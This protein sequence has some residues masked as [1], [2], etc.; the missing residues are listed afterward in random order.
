[1]WQALLPFL[2][3]L[4]GAGAGIYQG[5]KE[6]GM[7]PPQPQEP[8]PY[9]Y[10]SGGANT[11]GGMTNPDNANLA[12]WIA[13]NNQRQGGMNMLSGTLGSLGTMWPG[14]MGAMG[15]GGGSTYGQNVGGTGANIDFGGPG[16]NSAYA[17]SIY[18]PNFG[19]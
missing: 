7:Q 13:Q 6:M 19:F 1:M 3:S 5:S 8:E 10:M 9:G 12:A 17:R 15:Y 4:L 2:P 18:G 11:R 14:M 16:Q